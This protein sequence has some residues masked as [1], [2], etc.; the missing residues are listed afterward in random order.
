[1]FSCDDP[2]AL[3][4]LLEDA[5]RPLDHVQV[6]QNC[7]LVETSGK[8]VLFDN[9]MGSSKLYGPDS[10]QLLQ[11][12]AAGGVDPAG[13][14]ALVLTHAH[15]DHCWGTMRDDG[16]P[17][18]PNAAIFIA[19]AEL[20]YWQSNPPGERRE[21]SLAGVRKHLLPL[22]DRITL[23]RDG[24]E[25]LPGI[26]AWATPGHTPGHMAYLFAGGW[27]L[28]GDVAFLDP[29]SFALPGAESIFDVDP[30]QAIATRSSVLARLADEKLKVIGYHNSWPGL[31]YVDRAHD[32]FR[33]V[34]L[35]DREAGS[36]RATGA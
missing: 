10:G 26:Q 5:G 18:F 28:T 7:L 13:I 34:P 21:R 33:F 16:V 24:E 20:A 25:F 11:H 17:N 36:M 31:G 29:V 2:S 19:E 22:R 6:E 3:Q 32:G 1:M 4:R 23:I 9:G 12:L 27:C 15:S 8:R 30:L 35:Q 14:D